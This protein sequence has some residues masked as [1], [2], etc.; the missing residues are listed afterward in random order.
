MSLRVKETGIRG[1]DFGGGESFHRGCGMTTDE[2]A[3]GRGRQ[4]WRDLGFLA[5]S[6]Q[7]AAA[8][9]FWISTL[10]VPLPSRLPLHST[11]TS[12][13]KNST[14]LPGVIL[15]LYTSPSVPIADVFFWTP[16]VIGGLGFV[17]SSALI[18]IETQRAWWKPNLTSLGTF[19]V[20][21]ILSTL[22]WH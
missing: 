21:R 2:F 7:F 12:K 1:L 17:V 5:S 8:T 10:C 16:Q 20:I 13:L 14:G 19:L 11:L 6:I 15:N 18:M 4:S 9:I 3:S 22:L